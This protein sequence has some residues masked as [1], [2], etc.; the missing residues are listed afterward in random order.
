M[1]QIFQ[2]FARPRKFHFDRR[3]NAEA[4]LCW[5]V[6]GV[7]LIAAKKQAAESFYER[8]RTMKQ[9]KNRRDGKDDHTCPDQHTIANRHCKRDQELRLQRRFHDQ[10]IDPKES[11]HRGQQ[12]GAEPVL[13]SFYNRVCDTVSFSEILVVEVDHHE[14]VVNHDAR[15]ADD[16][17]DAKQAQGNR[18]YVM[19]RDRANQIQRNGA[20]TM[21]FSDPI[22]ELIND[23]RCPSRLANTSLR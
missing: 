21:L 17:K 12:D 6:F 14:A 3:R 19:P 20:R 8:C 11:R 1:E 15:K 4:L 18:Q 16:P 13:C 9:N 10:R 7:G 22:S 2:N 5:N 23:A